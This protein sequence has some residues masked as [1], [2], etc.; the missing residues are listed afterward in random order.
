MFS[1]IL[2]PTGN[3]GACTPQQTIVQPINGEASTTLV[4]G[5]L[6]KFDLGDSS[7]RTDATTLT[8]FDSKTNPFN[9][10]ILAT[11][12]G[13]TT[14]QHGGI[15]GVVTEGGAPGVRV[16]VCIAGLVQ[17]KVTTTATTRPMTAGDTVL[18]PGAGVLVPAPATPSANGGTP[19]AI[20]FDTVTTTTTGILRNVLFNGFSMA[21]NNL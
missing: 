13:S 6:V 7:T 19:L 12:A 20:G 2:V 17:A 16:K 21:I 18:E 10:V 9:V 8:E 14:G 1:A 11:A 3:L 5:D 4:I 15:W